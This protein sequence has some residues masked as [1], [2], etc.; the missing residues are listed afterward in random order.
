M[1]NII[2]KIKKGCL[3][4]MATRKQLREE[5]KKQ[6][7][8]KFIS[9]LNESG[10][11]VLIVGS[12]KLAFPVTDSEDNEDFIELTIKIPT[13]ANK[14]TEPYDGYAMAED[15]EIHQREMAEKKAKAKKLKEE[16]IARDKL[17]RENKKR[18][19]EERAV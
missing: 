13:G 18:Q 9:F 5:I 10:E 16:K 4:F 8:E 15:Y 2:I 14:G 1:Y 7:M 3:F 11:D 6:Y 17:Y 19:K 12:N